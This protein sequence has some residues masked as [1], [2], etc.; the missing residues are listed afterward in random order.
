MAIEHFSSLKEHLSSQIIGQPALV[1][2][3]LVALLA[4]GHL[5]VDEVFTIEDMKLLDNT[6]KV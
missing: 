4:N 1:E 6:R 5:I 3:L 2:N